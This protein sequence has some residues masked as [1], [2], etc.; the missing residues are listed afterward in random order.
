MSVLQLLS[1]L[2]SE[3]QP[4]QEDLLNLGATEGIDEDMD[5]GTF[6]M[7]Q[8]LTNMMPQCLLE[9]GL[10]TFEDLRGNCS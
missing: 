10:T 6:A 9:I 3:I 8:R 5:A 4:H 1:K 2:D 7:Q